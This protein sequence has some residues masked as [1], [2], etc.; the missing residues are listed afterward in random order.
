MMIW[1]LVSK[2]KVEFYSYS[3][4]SNKNGNIA[5]NQTEKCMTA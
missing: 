4:C 5:F 2:T 3:L 1:A